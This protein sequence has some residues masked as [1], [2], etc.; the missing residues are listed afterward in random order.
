MDRRK[1]LQMG[2]ERTA[3]AAMSVVETRAEQRARRWIRP[4]YA[5]PELDFLLNCTRC[6]ECIEACPHDVIFPLPA[7]VGLDVAETPAMD[8]IHKGCHLCSDWPCVT[9]CEPNAL[10]PLFGRE[11]QTENAEPMPVPL[12]RLARAE[13][14]TSQCLPFQGPECGACRDSCPIPDTLVWELEKPSINPETCIGCALCRE[15][16]VVEPKAVALQSLACAADT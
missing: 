3:S 1:F 6:G 5:Q 7:R 10:D 11:E 4:P 13:I 16:C 15:A 12:P 2:W 8:L 9:A 14:D